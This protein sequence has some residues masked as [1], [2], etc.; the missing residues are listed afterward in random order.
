MGFDSDMKRLII[1]LMV[2]LCVDGVIAGEVT[3]LD[4]EKEQ[5]AGV[6]MDVG[7]IVKFEL[8]NGE[9]VIKVREIGGGSVKFS[10]FPF[11]TGKSIYAFVNEGYSSYIDLDKND[12]NDVKISLYQ[13]RSDERVTILFE[14]VN[15]GVVDDSEEDAEQ[16]YFDSRFIWLVWLLALGAVIYLFLFRKKKK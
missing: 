1:L 13:I 16:D 7:D 10:V 15:Q 3:R 4:F 12:V 6:V 2:L 11:S 14:R 5:Q 9:H 8:L